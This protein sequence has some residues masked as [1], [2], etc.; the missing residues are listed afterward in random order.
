MNSQASG[1]GSEK[2]EDANA[3]KDSQSKS[4]ILQ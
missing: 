4:P 3:R 2:M 1:R